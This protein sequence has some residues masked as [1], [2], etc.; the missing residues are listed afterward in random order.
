[1]DTKLIA[2]PRSSAGLAVLDPPADPVE[3]L[4][5]RLGRGE[6]QR[7]GDLRPG[8]AGG[9]GGEEQ[10][11][12][13]LVDLRARRRQQGQGGQQYLLAGILARVAAGIA[14]A[15]W[16]RSIAGGGWFLCRQGGR[17]RDEAPARSRC[18]RASAS[19]AA[20]SVSLSA[21]PTRIGYQQFVVNNMLVV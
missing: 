8:K 3:A 13:Q 18:R 4:L 16:M 21:M 9:A 19:R 1:V 6:S 7:A 5:R 14:R 12:L 11:G 10:P 15:N 20:W 2:P 17:G